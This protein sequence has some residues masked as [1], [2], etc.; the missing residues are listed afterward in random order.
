MSK[1]KTKEQFI[2]DGSNVHGISRYNYSK[3]EYKGNHVPVLI[4]CNKYKNGCQ[5]FTYY[6]NFY[7]KNLYKFLSYNKKSRIFTIN[8]NTTTKRILCIIC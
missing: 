2:I 5:G 3:V 4:I 8:F 7:I 1:L 6:K